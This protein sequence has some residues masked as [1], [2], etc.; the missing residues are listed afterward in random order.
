MVQFLHEPRVNQKEANIQSKS[1][2]TNKAL[3]CTINKAINFMNHI[4]N[5]IIFTLI[6]KIQSTKTMITR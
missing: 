3:Q 5:E 2:L 4:Q 1:R 6:R